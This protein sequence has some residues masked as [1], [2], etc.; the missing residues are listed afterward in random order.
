M[1]YE[2]ALV[3]KPETDEAKLDSLKKIVHDVVAQFEGEVIV[4]DD[5]GKKAFA[6]P[7]SEGVTHAQFLYFIFKANNENNVELNRRF[8]ISEDVI[9]S[10]IFKLGED[11][12]ADAIVKA[13][14]TPFSKK[15]PGSVTDVE[16]ENSGDMEKN[17]K[18]FARR[19]S[20]WFT[21]NKIKADWKDPAT[22]SWLV[23]EFGKIS[24]GR[25]SGIT[26]KHQKI[27]TT[28][29]KR[30]RQLGIASYLSNRV[31]E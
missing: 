4:E 29:I 13:Y 26:R 2:L 30:A 20:C 28:S 31:T 10:S 24:P 23:N 22:Y 21:A 1:I 25:I 18:R 17:R 5:W 3:A 6:Q 19:K 16:G 14:K 27:A 9:K 12:T 8:G 7:T 11:N 15:Y